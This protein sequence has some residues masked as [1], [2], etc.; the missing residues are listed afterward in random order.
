ML[1]YDIGEHTI[2]L[3]EYYDGIAHLLVDAIAAAWLKWSGYST[4]TN[5]I[6]Y[7]EQSKNFL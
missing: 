1:G 4:F 5:K 6:I 7:A 2:D 3:P